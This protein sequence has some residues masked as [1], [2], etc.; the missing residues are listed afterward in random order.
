MYATKGYKL[1]MHYMQCKS[2][3]TLYTFQQYK[4]LLGSASDVF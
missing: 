1:H 2:G 4:Q 3:G